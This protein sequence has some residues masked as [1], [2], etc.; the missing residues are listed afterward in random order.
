MTS[1]ECP[2][3]NIDTQK[4]Q[5]NDAPETNMDE[6]TKKYCEDRDKAKHAEI[7]GD[8]EDIIQGYF[9]DTQEEIESIS[10]NKLLNDRL[11]VAIDDDDIPALKEFFEL[12]IQG[13]EIWDKVNY[14]GLS[15]IIEDITIIDKNAKVKFKLLTPERTTIEKVK[16]EWKYPIEE[17]HWYEPEGYVLIDSSIAEKPDGRTTALEILAKM[18]GDDKYPS[19]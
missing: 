1:P 10:Y 16:D 2:S 4:K 15:G 12:Q 11:A 18:K 8:W 5:N 14:A 19:G 7:I 9:P 17:I 13:F 3:D 6:Y